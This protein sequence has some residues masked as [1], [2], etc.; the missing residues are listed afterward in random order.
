MVNPAGKNIVVDCAASPVEPGQEAAWG[1]G[2]KFELNRTTCFLLHHYCPRPDLPAANKVADLEL[3]KIAAPQFAV[4][5]QIE[6]RPISQAAAPIEVEPDLPNL[7]R[8][9]CAVR[10]DGSSC[11]LDRAIGCGGVSF[12]HLNV[13]L[14]MARVAV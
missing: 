11:I 4:D 6:Q 3:D 8:F 14:P 10:A 2:E 1:V 9:Q 5:C 12:R 7:L 13:H